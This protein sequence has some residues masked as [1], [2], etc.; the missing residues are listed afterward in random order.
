MEATE[1]ELNRR[2]KELVKENLILEGDLSVWVQCGSRILNSS[3]PSY[4]SQSG[5]VCEF[6]VLDQ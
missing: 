6:K 4:P 5:F 2:K 3:R 1:R